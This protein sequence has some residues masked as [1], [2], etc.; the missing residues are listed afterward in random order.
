MSHHGPTPPRSVQASLFVALSSMAAAPAVAQWPTDP[1]S[2]LV[3]GHAEA[4]VELRQEVGDDGGTWLAW[5]D[6]QCFGDIRLQRIDRFG[7]V[8]APGGLVLPDSHPM[9]TCWERWSDLPSVWIEGAI[10]TSAFW[11]SLTSE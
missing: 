2:P 10:I 11:N 4:I 7:T 3:V 5:I 8:I 9:P 1:E 6:S